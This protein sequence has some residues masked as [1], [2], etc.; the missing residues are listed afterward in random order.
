MITNSI[1]LENVVSDGE[2]VRVGLGSLLIEG[3]QFFTALDPLAT[4]TAGK[5][6]IVQYLF[7]SSDVIAFWQRVSPIS[8]EIPADNHKLKSQLDNNGVRT[9]DRDAAGWPRTP[10]QHSA[11]PQMPTK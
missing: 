2:A 5:F 1:E 10:E 7:L 9:K 8:A 6:T 11:S 3:T 4:M